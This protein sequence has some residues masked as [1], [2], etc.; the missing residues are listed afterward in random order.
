MA[1]SGGQALNGAA[2]GAVRVQDAHLAVEYLPTHGRRVRWKGR[3]QGQIQRLRG[4]LRCQR[5]GC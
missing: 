4:L 2:K 5:V 3:E 1:Q